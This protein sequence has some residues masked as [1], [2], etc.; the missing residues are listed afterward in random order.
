MP[1]GNLVYIG[2]RRTVT[3]LA[4]YGLGDAQIDAQDRVG[5]LF[6]SVLSSYNAVKAA[7]KLTVE[8]INNAMAQITQSV[9]DY[10]RQYASTSRGQAGNIYLQNLAQQ[11]FNDN[12]RKDLN[13][14]SQSPIVP[15]SVDYSG[16][17]GSPGLVFGPAVQ[18]NIIINAGGNAAETPGNTQPS[19]TPGPPSG[20]T[21]P[22]TEVDVTASAPSIFEEHPW[23]I[24]AAGL[25]VV[26]LLGGKNSR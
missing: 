11:I 25:A 7:G 1:R 23:M 19:Y 12:M 17:S 6:A 24:L 10:A 22:G 8:Y 15:G 2:Q 13:A 4:G 18:P 16:G 21:I 26:Y 14:F 3:G 9:D 20:I 5:Q